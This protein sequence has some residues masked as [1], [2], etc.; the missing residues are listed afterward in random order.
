MSIFQTMYAVQ[1][2]VTTRVALTRI[3]RRFI[4]R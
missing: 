1:R 3:E 2:P 4:A